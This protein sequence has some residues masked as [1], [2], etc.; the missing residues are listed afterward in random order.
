M[1]PKL[2]N[3]SSYTEP[4]HTPI[5]IPDSHQE[6]PCPETT[7]GALSSS[8][9]AAAGRVSSLFC[10]SSL[11]KLAAGHVSSH[12]GLQESGAELDRESVATSVFSLQSRG[13]RDRDT[14]AVHS[15]R[16]RGNLQKILERKVDMAVRGERAAQQKL[17]QAEA[18][19]EA[20]NWEKQRQDFAFRESNQEFES[21]RFRIHQASR[22][23]DQ[24]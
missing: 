10:H 1:S 22:W 20:R 8:Q 7:P 11:R 17:Y 4:E 19:V 5:D 14:N 18:E 3:F 21:Q 24:A 12:S 6:F 15:L 2:A 16:D 23:V 9:K 13:K